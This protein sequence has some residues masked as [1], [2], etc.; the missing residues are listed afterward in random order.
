MKSSKEY[1][2]VYHVFV[3]RCDKRDELEMYLNEHGIGT[4]KH[5]P[6]PMHLQPCYE[7]LKLSEGALPIAEEI[8]STVLSIPMYY[9][10]TEE[11]VSYVIDCLNA[12]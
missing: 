7:E 4:V 9:G 8:S 1:E 3:I 5:Y 6:T 11:E 12:F 2:H 10:M